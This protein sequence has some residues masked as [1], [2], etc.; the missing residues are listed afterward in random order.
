M[1]ACQ[2][3]QT[4]GKRSSLTINRGKSSFKKEQVDKEVWFLSSVSQESRL[5]RKSSLRA[6]KTLGLT[7]CRKGICGADSARCCKDALTCRPTC[8]VDDHINTLKEFSGCGSQGINFFV[9]GNVNCRDQ[10][11]DYMV[12]QAHKSYS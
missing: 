8:V 4:T 12:V 6:Y 9:V 5:I 2:H 11:E 3:R 1:Q 10:E 7:T